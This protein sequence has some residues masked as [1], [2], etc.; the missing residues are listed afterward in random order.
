M[1]QL[2]QVIGCSSDQAVLVFS[3]RHA[4]VAVIVWQ[5][6]QVY[7]LSNTDGSASTSHD[8]Y[9]DIDEGF[10]FDDSQSDDERHDLDTRATKR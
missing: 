4:R 3:A 2:V 1:M 6:L 5:R 7:S 10:A 8:R 9:S